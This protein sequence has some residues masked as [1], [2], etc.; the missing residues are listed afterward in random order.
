MLE[1]MDLRNLRGLELDLPGIIDLFGLDII[2]E[3]AGKDKLIQKIG[4]EEAIEIASLYLTRERIEELLD[5]KKKV[6]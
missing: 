1:E 4:P 3:T 5:K 6:D 2:V